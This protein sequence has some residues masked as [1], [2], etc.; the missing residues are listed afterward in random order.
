MK[1]DW[2]CFAGNFILNS[3]EYKWKA[4]N[5]DETFLLGLNELNLLVSEFDH[6]YLSLRPVLDIEHCDTMWNINMPHNHPG[7]IINCRNGWFREFWSQHNKC[8]FSDN[9]SRKCTGKE[10]ITDYEQEG[11][12]PFVGKLNLD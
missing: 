11:L 12:V 9:S 1:P 2:S 8:N 10:N 3:V 4:N 6:Y 7:L 5:F